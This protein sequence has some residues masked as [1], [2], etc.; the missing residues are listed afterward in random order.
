MRRGSFIE[1]PKPR[2]TQYKRL[3]TKFCFDSVNKQE[4]NTKFTC[5]GSKIQLKSD[6]S[7]KSKAGLE[8]QPKFIHSAY[9][10]KITTINDTKKNLLSETLNPYFFLSDARQ[11]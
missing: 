3:R 5:P 7:E 8:S 1:K 4:K 10:G 6:I 9:I 2:C 11:F